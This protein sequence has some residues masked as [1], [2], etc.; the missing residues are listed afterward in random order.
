M[1]EGGAAS[2][3]PGF[4]QPFTC[5]LPIPPPPTYQAHPCPGA[6]ARAVPAAWKKVPS[7][8]SGISLLSFR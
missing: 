6:F 5:P 3:D 1:R 7:G 2:W 4:L 8:R